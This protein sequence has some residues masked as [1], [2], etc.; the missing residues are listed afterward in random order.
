MAQEYG[1]TTR[2]RSYQPL[3][4]RGRIWDVTSA[5][6][7]LLPS[8]CSELEIEFLADFRNPLLDYLQILRR[9]VRTVRM[10]AATGTIVV[11]I[12]TTLFAGF[13]N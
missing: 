8:P 13:Y 5:P 10:P 4:F 1:S 12:T 6:G 3:P 2:A 11:L 7:L 9:T